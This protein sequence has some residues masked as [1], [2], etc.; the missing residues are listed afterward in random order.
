VKIAVIPARGGSK[1]IPRKNVRPFHGKPILAYAIEAA[2]ES[3]LF[4]HVVVS[5]DDDEIAAVAL[6]CGAEVPFRRPAN[7]SDDHTGTNAVARHA[8]TWFEHAGRPVSEV[9]CLYA[10]APFVTASDLRAARG[11]LIPQVDFVFAATGFGFPVQRALVRNQLGLVEPMFPQWI[12]A[13]SQDL[14]EAIHDAGQF[15]WG[16]SESFKSHDIVFLA[17]SV[18]FALPMHRVQDID[19]LDDWTRAEL[20]YRLARVES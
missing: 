10:T 3:A 14:P 8:I 9:C 4:D 18:A 12:G 17:H 20:L 15:Y 19:T 6:Q 1:R 13:R 2:L 11:H 5:T 7:L 16:W